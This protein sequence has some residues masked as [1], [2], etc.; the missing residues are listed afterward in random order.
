LCIKCLEKLNDFEQYLKRTKI[1][2]FPLFLK[3]EDQVEMIKYL[4]N[5]DLSFF[6]IVEHIYNLHE[7]DKSSFD[8]ILLHISNEILYYDY[9]NNYQI[10]YREKYKSYFENFEY[11]Y[12]PK[13]LKKHIEEK[14]FLGISSQYYFGSLRKMERHRKYLIYKYRT[15]IFDSIY[16]NKRS[17]TTEDIKEIVFTLIDSK[18]RRNE[19]VSGKNICTRFL[20][21]YLNS[22]LFSHNCD[23][24]ITKNKEGEIMLETIRKEK[25]EILKGYQIEIDSDDRFGYYLG[26]LIYYLIQ[27]SKT[28]NRMALL[29][30]IISCQST[31]SLQRIVVEKYIEKYS[32]E[33]SGYKDF[34]HLL[35]AAILG[36]LNSKFKS[37]F[38]NI[39]MP[40]YV[41]FFDDNIFF[42]KGV[43]KSE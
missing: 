35:I 8:F 13:Y 3:V 18:I 37:P 41:G 42:M 21:F 31:E 38:N 29:N 26:Q 17:L 30:P 7:N 19:K 28:Q 5:P 6:D 12:G 36:Y 39:K 40:F 10:H 23:K 11:D 27:K 14:T 25:Q 22:P 1:K 20:D 34:K 9:I 24:F 33:L 2:F 15:K 4:K 32:R 43:E 16:R